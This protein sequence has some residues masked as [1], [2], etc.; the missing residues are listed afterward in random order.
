MILQS[1]FFLWLYQSFVY[2]ILESLDEMLPNVFQGSTPPV[3]SHF[4]KLRNQVTSYNIHSFSHKMYWKF[5]IV[6]E[7]EMSQTAS[8]H[9]GICF[10]VL[11]VEGGPG[12]SENTS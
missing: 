9:Q 12:Y 7:T 10:L 5:N 2:N 1:V 4:L 6:L 3:F 11:W 8:T